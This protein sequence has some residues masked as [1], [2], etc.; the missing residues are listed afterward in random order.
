[1]SFWKTKRRPADTLMSLY[2]RQKSRWTCERCKKLCRTG[3]EWFGDELAQL[4]ASHYYPRGKE[5]TRFDPRN[6][7]ALCHNCHE[8]MGERGNAEYDAFMLKKWG[9][10]VLQELLLLSQPGH[11]PDDAMVKLWVK[12]ELRKMGVR[13]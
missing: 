12:S 3:G 1:M 11:K 10:Q 9:P 4:E 6:L 8:R 2:I 5:G 7:T 13:W